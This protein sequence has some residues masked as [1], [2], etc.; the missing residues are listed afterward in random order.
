MS[1]ATGMAGLFFMCCHYNLPLW[2][3]SRRC[4][5][6]TSVAGISATLQRRDFVCGENCVN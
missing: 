1:T 4:L 3:K 6:R 2:T 5:S